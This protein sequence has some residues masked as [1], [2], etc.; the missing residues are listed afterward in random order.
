MPIK[1]TTEFNNTYDTLFA[2][3]EALTVST[4]EKDEHILGLDHRDVGAAGPLS[5]KV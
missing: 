2:K 5:S 1:H 3:V 4:D